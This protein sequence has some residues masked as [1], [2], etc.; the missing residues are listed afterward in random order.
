M[1][2]PDVCSPDELIHVGDFPTRFVLTVVDSNTCEPIDLSAPAVVVL[3]FGT[4]IFKFKKPDGTIIDKIG[5]F[6]TDGTDGKVEYTTSDED[7]IDQAGEW[8]Y[9]VM[10]DD[11]QSS[12]C[13][14]RAYSKF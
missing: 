4:I 2:C 6:T 13:N 1:T 3:A 9:R 10:L 8:E 7:D 12:T 5:S 14:F 11:Y